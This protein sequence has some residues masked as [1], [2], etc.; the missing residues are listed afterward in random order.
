M[1]VNVL[2]CICAAETHCQECF[3][4]HAAADEMPRQWRQLDLLKYSKVLT[5]VI[6]ATLSLL[7]HSLDVL[8]AMF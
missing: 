4:P 8:V 3:S 6:I 2:G 5:P 1:H 7:L